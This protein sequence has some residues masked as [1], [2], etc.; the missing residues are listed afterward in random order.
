MLATSKE[1]AAAGIYIYASETDSIDKDV[2]IDLYQFVLDDSYD[3]HNYSAELTN[4]VNAGIMTDVSHIFD[5]P[6]AGTTAQKAFIRAIEGGVLPLVSTTYANDPQVAV[7]DPQN[8]AIGRINPNVEFFTR[9]QN[10]KVITL[11]KTHADAINNVNPITFASGQSGTKFNVFA[12][13]R[14]SP[15]KFDPGFTDAT[16]TDGKWYIHCK[17]EVTGQPDNVKKNNIFWRIGKSDYQDRQR[18]T[19]MWYERLEDNRDK[20][21]RTYKIRMVIPKYLENARDPIRFRS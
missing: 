17:D 16:S 11:H 18:S 12:N 14:R 13:K 19:D 2:E 4:T 8:A 6:I 21:E 1:N 10:S 9:Y 5:I 20:D 3:L 7:T 15:M